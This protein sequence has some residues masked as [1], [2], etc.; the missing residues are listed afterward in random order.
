MVDYLGRIDNGLIIETP[1]KNYI[2]LEFAE[3]RD[4]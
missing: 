3:E 4:F 1:K 2:A